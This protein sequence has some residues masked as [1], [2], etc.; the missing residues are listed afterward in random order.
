MV[1][2][3]HYRG[4]VVHQCEQRSYSCVQQAIKLSEDV[5]V[6]IARFIQAMVRTAISPESVVQPIRCDL[7]H[8]EE[9]PWM[10]DQEMRSHPKASLYHCTNIFEKRVPVTSPEVFDIRH[11]FPAG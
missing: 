5:L 4:I 7:H 10:P 6:P 2:N 1:R 8:H 9:S 3:H 11:V